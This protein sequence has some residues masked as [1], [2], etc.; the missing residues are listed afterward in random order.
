M[1]TGDLFQMGMTNLWRTKL[2]TFLTTLGVTI[3]IGALVSMVSFGTGMQKNVTD[4]FLENDL[5]TSMQVTSQRVDIEEIMSGNVQEAVESMQEESV[6]LNDSILSVI[7]N[8]P[9]VDIAF[10]EI[11][12]PV[13]IRLGEEEWSCYLRAL[14]A[15]MGRYKP[16]S[17][18]PHGNFFTSDTAS[19]LVITPRAL[20]KLKIEVKD[21]PRISRLAVA[22][23]IGGIRMLAPDSIIGLPVEVISSTLDVS[24]MMKNPF[25]HLQPNARLPVKETAITFRICGI[26]QKPTGFDSRQFG[27]G[28]VV[29][30]QSAGKIPQLGFSSVWD[31]LKDNHKENSFA[32]LYVRVE[33]ISKMDSVKAG[34]KRM[35]LGVFSIADQLEEIKR[36][37]I[38][39][40]IALGTIGAI[41]L[42]VAALGIINTMVM[43]IL[44]RT[45][46]IGIMK[47]I[48]GSENEI[49]GIFFIEA[50]SIG[51]FGGL[52]GLGLGWVITR[53]TN[54]IA[55]YYIVK[56]GGMHVDL[57]YIPAWL[58]VGAM[59]FSILVSLLAGLYP[60]VRAARVDPVEALRH[61]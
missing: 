19:S 9:G 20:G 36:G 33:S 43:S 30:I 11:R 32:S 7:E 16:F 31:L 17:E 12:F 45:R 60:A 29:P 59:V 3:G 49:K 48:G 37:F 1:K 42:L 44:E 24:S 57:F 5:F 56:E 6:P 22:D 38:V 4:A 40:D 21:G 8:I 28:I 39:L 47:A 34:I 61:D 13:K 55:N 51:F 14:P 27:A 15:A 52:F 2:R 54:I 53:I 46:E 35:G 58:I 50:G 10:P 41:A 18:I 23:S 26:Q 25:A